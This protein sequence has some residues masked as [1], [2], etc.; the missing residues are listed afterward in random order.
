MRANAMRRCSEGSRSVPNSEA[1]AKKIQKELLSDVPEETASY[2]LGDRVWANSVGS[3]MAQKV[4]SVG[5][6]LSSLGEDDS[7]QALSSLATT[8]LPSPTRESRLQ[9]YQEGKVVNLSP[10]GQVTV[11]FPTGTVQLQADELH[12]LDGEEVGVG[13][14]SWART[15]SSGPM[16][17]LQPGD[18]FGELSLLYNIRR[19]ATVKAREDC[20]IYVIGRQAFRKCLK[21]EH[22]QF[23]EFLNLLDEVHM[24]SSLTRA[25]RFELARNANGIVRFPPG[26]RVIM[27]GVVRKARQWYIV[28]RGDCI[29]TRVVE[30]YRKERSYSITSRPACTSPAYSSVAGSPDDSDA[31]ESCS[32]GEP[33]DECTPLS[34]RGSGMVTPVIRSTSGILPP[35]IRCTSGLTETVARFG[36]GGH[37]GER[38]LMRGDVC[39]EISVDAGPDGM[40]CLVI[41]GEILLSLRLDLGQSTGSMRK[42]VSPDSDKSDFEEPELMRQVSPDAVNDDVVDYFHRMANMRPASPTKGGRCEVKFSAL[43]P[44]AILGSGGFGCVYLV[45]HSVTGKEYALKQLSKGYIIESNATRQ[46]S[47]ERDIQS[48]LDS[49][50]IVKFFRTFQDYD[51]VYMLLEAVDGGNLHSL[52]KRTNILFED[53]PRGSASA[54]YVACMIAALEYMHVRNIMY[55]DLKLENVL[56][57]HTSGYAKLCDMGLSRFCLGQSNT[58]LG[59]PDYM[60]P[61]MI[62]IPHTH[63]RCVDWWALGVLTFELL[64]GQAPFDN[65]GV[66]PDEDHFVQLLAFR[67]SHE[68]GIPDGVLPTQLILAKDFIKKLTVVNPRKRLGANGAAALR[69][70]TWFTALRFDFDALMQQKLSA[71][72][73]P[74]RINRETVDPNTPIANLHRS[75]IYATAENAELETA[76]WEDF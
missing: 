76:A 53:R 33:A 42:Q 69:E 13:S 59:T 7:S 20:E 25:E 3:N 27:Q 30:V 28:S 8:P 34:P 39:E 38:S 64:T 40:D 15:T 44:L 65:E 14:T 51:F 22:P 43:S 46:L 12:H 1:T 16:S 36:R 29:I 66:D 50:F 71:P 55:R 10:D 63:D 60:A 67:R 56:L 49:P 48:M 57:S 52:I 32:D 58:L 54:F 45:K 18:T 68:R 4:G 70:H 23:Q 74:D 26:E 37:F 2:K 73:K 6:D 62:D 41:D 47:Y 72:F 21:Y 35:V 31:F 5:S 11:E 24:L 61:E 75:D 17:V 19:E 9:K